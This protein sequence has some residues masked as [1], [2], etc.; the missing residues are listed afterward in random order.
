MARCRSFGQASSYFP[1]EGDVLVNPHGCIGVLG[2]YGVRTVALKPNK[3]SR[4]VI[5]VENGKEQVDS[6]A[7][8]RMCILY[9]CDL[10]RG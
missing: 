8:F 5:V 6:C 9:I 4:V 7:A 2:Q 3:W 1:T 10:N